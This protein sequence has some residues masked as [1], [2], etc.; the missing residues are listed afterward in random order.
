MPIIT[1]TGREAASN[2][3]VLSTGRLVTIPVGRVKVEV[4]AN[5]NDATNNFVATLTLPGGEAPWLTIQVPG[6]NPALTGVL[7]DR[8]TLVGIFDITEPGH[9]TLAVVESGTALLDWRITS[10]S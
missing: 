6:S 4:Q 3:D 1:E 10:L 7:D 5:A 2:A 9:L 8:Q